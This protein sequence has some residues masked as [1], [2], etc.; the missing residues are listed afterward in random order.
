MKLKKPLDESYSVTTKYLSQTIVFAK[1]QNGISMASS[2]LYVLK[3][4]DN[5]YKP[6]S[7]NFNKIPVSF[8][9]SENSTTKNNGLMETLLTYSIHGKCILNL[10]LFLIL[11]CI[12]NKKLNSVQ[13]PSHELDSALYSQSRKVCIL[14]CC[15]ILKYFKKS[16]YLLFQKIQN[17]FTNDIC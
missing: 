2:Y 12:V 7:Q 5:G 10:P 16:L 11:S 1:K 13:P 8:I 4:K 14:T 17:N 6:K 3:W 15:I 9:Y